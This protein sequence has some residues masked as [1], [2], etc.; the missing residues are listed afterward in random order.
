ML[1]SLILSVLLA[2]CAA[3]AMKF[4]VERSALQKLITPKE[5]RGIVYTYQV[6]DSLLPVIDRC[7]VLITEAGSMD[8]SGEAKRHRVYGQLIKEFPEIERR[9][10]AFAI[11]V[12]MQN[13]GSET[14]R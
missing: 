7:H 1:P 14:F 9:N 13:R 11:E 5:E 3:V 8:A 6:E 12:A 4:Y 2:V 10:L